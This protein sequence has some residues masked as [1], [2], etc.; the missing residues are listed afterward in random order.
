MQVGKESR[1]EPLVNEDPSML[2]IVGE[3]NDVAMAVV[4]FKEMSLR[5]A[6]HFSQ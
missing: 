5:A 3:L 6:A 2:G 4:G 1:S